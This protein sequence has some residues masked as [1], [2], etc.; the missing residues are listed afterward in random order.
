MTTRAAA[1]HALPAIAMALFAGGCDQPPPTDAVDEASAAMGPVTAS[2][3]RAG[4]KAP[5]RVSGIATLVRQELAPQFGPPRF[6][7]S[8]FGDRCSIPSDYIIRFSLEGQA[9]HLGRFASTA[10]HCSLIDFPTGA[11]SIHDGILTLTAAD[12][13]ELWDRYEGQVAPTDAAAE[14]HT[15]VGGTGRFAGASGRGMSHVDC[16]RAAGTCVFE[17]EGV[18][19]FDASRRRR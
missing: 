1:L 3:V 7:K 18:L 8:T 15:F 17:L 9:T 5:F 13:D 6:G 2:P 12:G 4:Q 19:R 16:D 11:T 10:E 14:I